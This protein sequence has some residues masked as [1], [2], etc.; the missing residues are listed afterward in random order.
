[1]GLGNE[2]GALSSWELALRLDPKARL[3]PMQSPKVK[4]LF[5]KLREQVP[6]TP[7]EP[8]KE[9]PKEVKPDRPVAGTCLAST[10][11]SRKTRAKPPS[12][13]RPQARAHRASATARPG[14][15]RR[16]TLRH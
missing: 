11:P 7:Q 10:G 14:R 15:D 3:P 2:K 4:E 8:P 5:E 16:D 9:E 1:M 6:Q 13:V 12:P